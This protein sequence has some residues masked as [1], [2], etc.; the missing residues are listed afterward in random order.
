MPEEKKTEVVKVVAVKKRRP[1]R[2]F[3]KLFV[4]V[5]GWVSYDELSANTQTTY[6]L[7]RKF[8]HSS[9][10]PVR[11]ETY[12]EAAVRLGMT[13]DQLAKR[14]ETFLYSAL[15]Y[16]IFAFGLF[17]YFI[18]LLMH[19]YFLAVCFDL[20]L[21]LLLSLTAYRE[22]FWYMQMQKRRL[23]CNFYDWLNFVLRRDK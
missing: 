15:I 21:V 12:E 1:V 14:K 19:M 22:H 18:Y 17:A 2:A 13:E 8:F 10:N 9:R 20:M 6:G 7:F 16:W 3:F 23:G 5:R 11:H 4:N